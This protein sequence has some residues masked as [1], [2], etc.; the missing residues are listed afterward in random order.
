VSPGPASA[1]PT[2]PT[3]TS[4]ATPLTGELQRLTE[5]ILSRP[6]HPGPDP[7]EE[8][9]KKR[10]GLW[11]EFAA[12]IGRRYQGCGLENF[13]VS[14]KAQMDA[15]SQSRRYGAA[16]AAEIKAG[17]GVMLFG[18]AGTGKDH[19]LVALARIAIRDYGFP[20][21]WESGLSLFGTMRDRIGADRPE[22]GLVEQL[23]SP[24]ILIL[25]DPVPPRG[26][27]TD[28]QASLLLRIV[29]DRYRACRPTWVSLNV[30]DRKE[31]DERLS[32]QI[33]DRLADG[34]MVLKFD[35]PTHRTKG[36]ER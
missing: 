27:L 7:K 26:P 13:T 9:R 20:V 18:P 11:A 30:R 14:C 4:E 5:R 8:D 3:P 19:V 32:P 36:P 28:F 24:R 16:M 33:V 17:N 22:S 6:D 35:W 25:S 34:A 21:A 23:R 1:T 10:A 29:D 15:I 2:T 31:A 12:R